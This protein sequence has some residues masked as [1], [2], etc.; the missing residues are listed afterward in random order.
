MAIE[1]N[2]GN[3]VKDLTNIKDIFDNMENIGV[4]G[5]PSSTIT[6]SGNTL[7]PGEWVGVWLWRTIPTG[8]NAFSN[9]DCTIKLVGETT[10]SPRVTIEKSYVVSFGNDGAISVR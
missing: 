1:L 9:R 3:K 8:A 4:E 10:G 6:P 5:S 7:G 2:L